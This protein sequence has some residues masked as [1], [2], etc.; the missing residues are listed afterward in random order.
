MAEKKST[1]K[2]ANIAAPKAETLTQQL[3]A[4]RTELR[5]QTKSLRAGELVN[6][7]VVRSTRKDIAR[8]LTK[9]NAQEGD[10]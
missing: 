9:L 5:D 4:K 7:R 6:P 8:V 2:K 10:K 1:T 3:E